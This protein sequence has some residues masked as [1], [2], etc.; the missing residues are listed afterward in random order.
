MIKTFFLL[1][2]SIILTAQPKVK[3]GIDILTENNFEILLGKR[4][5]LI[6][7]HT[8]VNSKLVSTLK[9]FKENK[10]INLVAVFSPEHGVKGTIGAGQKFSDSIDAANNIKFYSLYGNTQKPTKEMMDEIDI[11][12]YDIQDIGCRSYTYISTLGNCMEAAAEF[13]KKLIVLDRPN[14]LGGLKIEG[15]LPD[16][17]MLS[18]VCKFK[19]PYVYGLTCGELA[20]MLNEER[21]LTNRMKC[22]LHVVKMDGWKRNMIFGDTGLLWVPTSP[23]V[24]HH[25]TPFYLVASGILG[26]LVT[27]GIGITFTLSFQTFAAEWINEELLAEQMN[28]LNLPGVIFRP[29]SYKPYYGVWKDVVLNGVQIHITDFEKVNLTEMQFYFMQ[30][31]KKLYPD[32]DIFKLATNARLKMFDMVLGSKNIRQ[33]FTK[34]WRVADIK[35]YFARD[36]ESFRNISKKYYL[37]N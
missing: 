2:I 16:E 28:A 21:M 18:F 24:P 14:P 33:A 27:V 23:N 5:G 9:I 13:S 4:V 15:N 34:R 12:V 20:L 6:T 36:I 29:I 3:L 11:L 25:E 35:R 30:V 8:G 17:E 31:N 26:E 19:I 22:D 37:Y 1:L 32:K 10:A 7:N